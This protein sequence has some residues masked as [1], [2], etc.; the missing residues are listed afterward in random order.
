MI[1]SLVPFGG[2]EPQPPLADPQQLAALP[3]RT[4]LAASPYFSCTV[5]VSAWGLRSGR[6]V[7]EKYGESDGRAMS[8]PVGTG[9]YKLGQWMRSNKIVLDANPEYRGFTWDFNA[10]Q[11]GD[12]KLVAQMKGKT[13]AAVGRVEVYIMEEDQTRWLA[14]QS[15]EL[16]FMNM[17]GP[18][19]PNAIGGDGSLKPELA[20]KGMRLDRYVDPEMRYM[21]W[22][23]LDP[24]V[25]GLGKPQ[26]AL[27]RALAMS[28]DAVRGS[29]RDPER[30]GGGG[31]SI[32]SRRASW[33]TI[34]TGRARSS[35][36]RRGPT[37]CSTSSGTSAAPTASARSPTASRW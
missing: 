14:F 32:R 11:P 3:L 25:G 26:I 28:Y 7:I 16:D 13:D 29:A 18:L 36:T 17:E 9:P 24:R 27:R 20:A 19:A 12:D 37:R 2:A 6:E 34:P 22:N 1:G 10:M 8:N 23:M 30:P 21:Y 31:A 35:T 4:R 15:G 33:A 5:A